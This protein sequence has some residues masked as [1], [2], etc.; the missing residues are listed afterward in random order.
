M[1]PDAQPSQASSD[2]CTE[3]AASPG[4]GHPPVG[5]TE[6]VRALP[7][8]LC[9]NGALVSLGTPAARLRNTNLTQ[10]PRGDFLAGLPS[11]RIMCWG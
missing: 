10:E 3:P 6:L 1:E 8:L 4:T 5:G 7:S 2:V 9:R 11:H